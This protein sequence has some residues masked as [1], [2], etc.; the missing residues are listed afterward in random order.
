MTRCLHSRFHELATAQLRILLP[1]LIT[2]LTVGVLVE[3]W[4]EAV[5]FLIT[6]ASQAGTPLFCFP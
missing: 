2:P 5:V 3:G 4:E 6:D 1:G